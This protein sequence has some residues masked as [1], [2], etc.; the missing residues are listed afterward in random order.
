MQLLPLALYVLCWTAAAALALPQT[1]SASITS[2]LASY[3]SASATA[4]GSI[5]ANA[6]SSATPTSSAQLPSLSGYSPC[7]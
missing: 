4:A 5:S 2:S 7:G 6:S 3:L 1:S